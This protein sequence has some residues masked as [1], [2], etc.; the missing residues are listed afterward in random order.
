MGYDISYHPISEQQIETWYFDLLKNPEKI[1]EV[2]ATHQLEDFYKTKYQDTF[3]CG[4][5]NRQ[6]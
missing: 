4:P 2:S 6:K 3:K 1:E 5:G